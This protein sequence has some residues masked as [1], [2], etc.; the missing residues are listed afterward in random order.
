VGLT[1]NPVDAY[2]LDVIAGRI[3]AGK[4]HRLACTRHMADRAR[5]NTP[6]FPYRFDWAQAERFLKFAGLMKHYKG[7]Q[8]AGTSFSPTPCQVFRLGSIF[9]WRQMATGLR[10]FTTAYNEVPRKQGKSFEEAVVSVYCTFFEGEAGAEGYCIAT[11]EKQAKIAFDAAKKLVKSSGLGGRIK[12]NAANL[13]QLKSESKLEPLGSDSDTT[14]GLNPHFVG[15][16]EL[17][18]FKNRGLLDVMESATGA[19]LNPLIFQITTA[20]DDPVSVCGDQHDYACKILDGVLEDDASTLSFFAFIAHADSAYSASYDSFDALHEMLRLC[21]CRT[22][23]SDDLRMARQSVI[24]TESISRAAS[25]RTA[26][27]A[28]SSPSIPAITN[29]RSGGSESGLSRTLIGPG[30]TSSD[31]GKTILRSHAPEVGATISGP[32]L[33]SQ[34]R[35]TSDFSRSSMASAGSA[36]LPWNGSPLITAMRLGESGAYSAS[37][38]TPG[39]VTSETLRT[40]FYAH[41]TTC[42]VRRLGRLEGGRFIVSYPEDDPWAESTWQKA[43][44]HWGI[45]VN[46]EDMRKLAAKA[47]KMPSAAAEFKQKRLNMWVNATAPC[48]SVDGWRKGQSRMDRAAFEAMLEHESCFV[49]VDLASKIDLCVLSLVFPP[50]PGRPKLC[51]IQRIWTPADT[52]AERAHRD[53]A[54]YEVWRDQG[55]LMATPGTRID[56]RVVREELALLRTKYDIE[57]IGFDPWHADHLVDE[58]VKDDGFAEES[59][60]GVAQTYQGM[61]SACL[62]MQAEILDGAVDACGCPVTAWSGANTVGQRDGKDNLMFAKGRSRGRID[63]IIAPTIG[64]ALWIREPAPRQ[65]DVRIEVW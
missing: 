62:R 8:F 23:E 57:R 49:G 44:P 41:S 1:T 52:L 22:S 58:L 15:V 30:V 32:S 36:A 28:G 63:P 21:S 10:R 47:Q 55:W 18:A 9:G 43:N 5:E 3:P 42:G 38:A 20:G 31:G 11:K 54:P 59:V 64:V 29:D 46:P 14:D 12:I 60:I 17:H 39:S 4:Y 33:G 40:E 35:T 50:T 26:T 6:G 16:D 24:Q 25:A 65:A 2:A 34:S 27:S 37:S 61:S 19:R 13:H 53:R 56:H 7:R 51:V 48:L 45:S